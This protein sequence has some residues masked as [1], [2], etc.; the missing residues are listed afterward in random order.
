MILQV[1]ARQETLDHVGDAVAALIGC[2][3]LKVFP[4]G[5]PVH[6]PPAQ[7]AEVTCD[8]NL[9]GY[10]KAGF[11][12]AGFEVPTPTGPAPAPPQNNL[13]TLTVTPAK[14][15]TPENYPLGAQES[16]TLAAKAL[17]GAYVT[18]PV[19]PNADAYIGDP[20]TSMQVCCN[21]ADVPRVQGGF[22]AAKFVAV[23]T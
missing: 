16:G 5:E 19:G 22:G 7:A 10:A 12:A 13:I 21:Q 3:I 18:Q 20:G 9:A 14:P 15:D 1:R 11:Y 6:V 23:P 17:N 8:D 2:G 4:D